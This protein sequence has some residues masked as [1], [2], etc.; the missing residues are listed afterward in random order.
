MGE[1]AAPFGENDKGR[2]APEKI[3]ELTTASPSDFFTH[4]SSLLVLSNVRVIHWG[5]D[6]LGGKK[7]VFPRGCRR[8]CRGLGRRIGADTEVEVAHIIP[9][10]GAAL[11]VALG[12]ELGVGGLDGG[13]AEVVEGGEASDGGEFVAD[14]VAGGDLLFDRLVELDMQRRGG[15]G[16][17]TIH[18]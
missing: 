7:V 8:G 10:A 1:S 14:A 12:I 6:K 11:D 2:S 3:F 5:S 16:I 18:N 17:E 4:T 15:I 13:F 9:A